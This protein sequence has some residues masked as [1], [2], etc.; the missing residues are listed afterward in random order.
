MKFQNSNENFAKIASKLVNKT[1]ISKWKI[2]DYLKNKNLDYFFLDP[3]NEKDIQD[4]VSINENSKT[5]GSKSVPAF[6]LKQFK[7][8]LLS[9]SLS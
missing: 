9:V 7:K 3:A 5:V 6:L 2:T 1:P 8:E 4:I